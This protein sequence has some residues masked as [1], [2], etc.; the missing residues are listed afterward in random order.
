MTD[1]QAITKQKLATIRDVLT[2]MQPQMKM[3][4]PRH[5]T[6]ERMMR[7]ALT[8][9]QHTPKLLDC[10]QPSL[11]GAIMQA[12]QLGLEP[13]GMLGQAY[14]V[15]YGKTCT[16][17]PGYRGFIS[18][19]RRSGDISTIYADVVYMGDEFRVVKG[20]N[21]ILEHTPADAAQE[22]KSIRGFYAVAK[23]KDGGQQFE[24]MTKAQVDAIRKK[25]PAGNS[26]PWVTHYAEMG[27]KTAIR[28]LFKYLPC[29]IE[30]QTAVELDERADAGV[31]QNLE[32]FI[33]IQSETVD[34]KTGEITEEKSKLDAVVD[35]A[36]KDDKPAGELF[37]GKDM[38]Q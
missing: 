22:D 16:L 37:T 23:L 25:S 35:K 30:L 26:G 29:S 14:L 4:L 8:A 36:K 33:D 2:K 5:V 6:P 1:T 12:A 17:I 32:G 27:K 31:P 34:E 18:L 10:T 15:P 20:L 21:P 9:I 7:V 28:R 3:A 11:L 38:A 19:A 24:Y 13:D